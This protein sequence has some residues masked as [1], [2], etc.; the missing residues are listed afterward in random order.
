MLQQPGAEIHSHTTCYIWYLARIT[1]YSRVPHYVYV[2]FESV[3]GETNVPS[4]KVFLRRALLSARSGMKRS[5][6]IVHHFVRNAVQIGLFA[7][8]WSLAALG[9]IFLWP[10]WTIHTIFDMTSGLIYTHVGSRSLQGVSRA[11][12]N[13]PSQMIFDGLLSRTRLRNRLAERSEL[14]L[15]FPSQVQY[16]TSLLVGLRIDSNGPWLPSTV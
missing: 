5:D 16:S 1:S 13:Y 11:Q 7:T 12:K 8:L 15:G 10:K 2:I 6:S 4:V 14:E 3:W 9:T